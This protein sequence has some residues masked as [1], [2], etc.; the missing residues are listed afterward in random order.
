MA[1]PYFDNMPALGKS[2]ETESFIVTQ[3]EQS[4]AECQKA[5]LNLVC[6][7]IERVLGGMKA[8]VHLHSTLASSFQDLQSRLLDEL[9]TKLF[10]QLPYEKRTYFDE[11]LRGGKK[12]LKGSSKL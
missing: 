9:D 6:V 2:P 7:Q 8:E 3:L 5:E 10:F 4:L 11:P 12:F 1:V